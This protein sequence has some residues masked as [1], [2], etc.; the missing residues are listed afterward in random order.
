MFT[1]HLKINDTS[2]PIALYLISQANV[3]A[4]VTVFTHFK[5]KL[6]HFNSN[7][8]VVSMM[9]DVEGAT[10]LAAQIVFQ[11]SDDSLQIYAFHFKQ[12]LLRKAKESNIDKPEGLERVNMDC[13]L[14]L[15]P[16]NK[17]LLKSATAFL[18]R[19][20]VDGGPCSEKFTKFIHYINTINTNSKHQY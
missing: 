18:Q 14:M 9:A 20:H 16:N 6:F 8:R 2:F 5:E 10:R 17:E 11:L 13:A 7:F 19:S 12:L 15:L 3:E 1:I 4:Y